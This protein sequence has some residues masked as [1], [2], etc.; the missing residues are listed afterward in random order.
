[1]GSEMCIRDS[2]YS[3]CHQPGDH[4]VTARAI[5][6][7]VNI[8][9]GLTIDELAQQRG[10]SKEAILA[11]DALMEQVGRGVACMACACSLFPQIE[12]VV[13][14]GHLLP[15]LTERDWRYILSRK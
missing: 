12:C 9:P 15:T 14:P 13:T 10:C 11:D 1:M 2:P 3:P 4:P 5:A 8:M 6:R 7:S